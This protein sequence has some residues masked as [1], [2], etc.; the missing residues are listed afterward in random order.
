MQQLSKVNLARA[1]HAG[2]AT[3]SVDLAGV[4]TAQGDASAD[5]FAQDQWNVVDEERKLIEKVFSVV[6]TDHSGQINAAKLEEMFKVF[7]V[8]TRFLTG[9]IDK[10]MAN[11]DKDH[12]GLISPTEFYTMLSQKFQKGDSEKEME[13]VFDR[14]HARPAAAARDRGKD[15]KGGEKEL[16][17]TELHNVSQMLGESEVTKM[18]IKDMIVC[19]KRLAV[20]PPDPNKPGSVSKQ[21][22]TKQE[23]LRHSEHYD[24]DD[25]KNPEYV[26]KLSEFIALMNMDL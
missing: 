9:A 15:G 7:G 25:E 21:K 3:F 12:D 14:M 6:D 17:I 20:P 11:V 19:F 4:G 13:D 5:I 10:I 2:G 1:E 24:E 22:K 8:D 26:L 18:Q 23:A 16:G